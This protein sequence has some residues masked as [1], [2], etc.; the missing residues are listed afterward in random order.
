[1]Q[2]RLLHDRH[3]VIG[4]Q[5]WRKI[6]SILIRNTVGPIAIRTALGSCW[7]LKRQ[8]TANPELL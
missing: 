7:R 6:S 3:G 1:M 4:L 2:V 8:I 5:H